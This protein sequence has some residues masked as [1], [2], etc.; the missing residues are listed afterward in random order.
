MLPCGYTQ[1][2]TYA[3]TGGG[4]VV[5][6]SGPKVRAANHVALVRERFVRVFL[7]W[8]DWEMVAC[9]TLDIVGMSRS[10]A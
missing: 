5:R 2:I 7:S 8:S 6:S 1:I 9:Q 10:D 4:R 3:R